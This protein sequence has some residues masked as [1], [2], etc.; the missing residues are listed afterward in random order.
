LVLVSIGRLARNMIAF[1]NP[2]ALSFCI[3]TSSSKLMGRATKIYNT[4]FRTCSLGKEPSGRGSNHFLRLAK[5]P[6]R[7]SSDCKL[8]LQLWITAQ[9]LGNM[10]SFS[11]AGLPDRLRETSISTATSILAKKEWKGESCGWAMV[12]SFTYFSSPESEVT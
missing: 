9:S 6:H 1:P 3:T 4:V 11:M 8:D 2:L 12:Y 5:T 10:R 7:M